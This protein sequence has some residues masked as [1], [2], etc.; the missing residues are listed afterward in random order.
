MSAPAF[1]P[2]YIRATQNAGQFT[3]GFDIVLW[4]TIVGG[5]TN[6]S[7][8]AGQFSV[9]TSGIFTI[10]FVVTCSIVA[11]GQI[12][13][14]LFNGTIGDVTKIVSPVV[15]G[16]DI[17]SVT[18]TATI[19]M[20]ATDFVHVSNTGGAIVQAGGIEQFISIVKVSD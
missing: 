19:P 3:D 7:Y 6:I 14:T 10:S 1:V 5:A 18:L 12:S 16:G 13:L 8:S 2:A 11:L 20:A 17:V 4:D 15:T 9:L